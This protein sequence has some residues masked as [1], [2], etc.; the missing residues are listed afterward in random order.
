MFRNIAIVCL[1]LYSS[2]GSG[3]LDLLDKPYVPPPQ[4]VIKIIDVE[5]PSASILNEVKDLKSIVT[6]EDDRIKLALFN[7]E[8]AQR[9]SNYNTNV[10]QVND[11]YTLA[12]KIFFQNTLVNKYEGLAEK[13]TSILDKTLTNENHVVTIEEKQLVHDYFIGI[14]WA[15]TNE[16]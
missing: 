13:I 9:I 7:Y 8:F 14:A 6:E 5:K 10:Q 12:G 11:V 16:E 1:L 15:L 4:P 3:L 2:F